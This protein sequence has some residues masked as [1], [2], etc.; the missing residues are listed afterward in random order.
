MARSLKNG[1]A[2]GLQIETADIAASAVTN[3]KLASNIQSPVTGVA[4]GYKIARGTATCTGTQA[5]NTGLSSI[6]MSWAQGK[7]N[8]ATKANNG[9]TVQ[10]VKTGTATITLYR[11]KVTSATN[12]TLV[13]ASTAGTVFWGAIGT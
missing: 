3:T 10:A 5:V 11:W 4:L 6:V 9:Y 1:V 8:T 2:Y 13:A 12:N 7:S